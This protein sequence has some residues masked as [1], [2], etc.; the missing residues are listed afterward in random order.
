MRYLIGSQTLTAGGV[1]TVSGTEVSLAAG[2]SD[3]VVG[4]STEALAP[5]I[6]AGFGAG[7]NGTAGLTFEG[8]AGGRLG[9]GWG[10]WDVGLVWIV[11]VGVGM[12]GCL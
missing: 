12:A 1:V 10:C 3:V 11:G 4:S 8:G 7:P 9:W 5:W 6:T 2:E